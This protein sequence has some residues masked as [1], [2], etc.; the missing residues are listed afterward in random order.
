MATPKSSFIIK[1]YEGFG[2]KF[3]DSQYLGAS[4]ESDKPHIFEGK[5]M[6]LYSAK[7]R[8]FTSPKQLV[9]MTGA[10][11][12]GTMEIT[13][14]VYRWFLQGAETRS[15]IVMAASDPITSSDVMGLGGTW[16]PLVLDVNWY[17]H[18][19]VLM[20]EDNN[21]PL[22]V[23]DAT[24]EGEF[25]RYMVRIQGDDPSIFFPTYLTEVGRR[26]DKAWT[27]VQS[28]YNEVFGTQQMPSIM[29]LEHQIG[30]FAQSIHV[31]DRALRQQG[32]LGVTFNMTDSNGN[33]QSVTNFVPAF[34][35]RMQEEFYTSMEVQFMYGKKETK[36]GQSGSYW[37]KTGAGI[38][39]Q[40]KDGWTQYYSGS[41]NANL[42]Q[43]YV[44]DILFARANESDRKITLMTG[45]VGSIEF[46][47]ALA[48][49]ASGF[50]TVDSNFIE[51]VSSNTETPHLA[52]G[53]QFTR[54]RGLEGVVI[55]VVKNP[56][57]DMDTYCKQQ[58]PYYPGRPLDSGRLTVLDFGSSGKDNNIMMLKEK[59]T[60]KYGYVPG[61]VGPNGPITSGVFG[62]LKNGYDVAIQ[63]TGG[64]WIKDVTRCGEL[65]LGI[66]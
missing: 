16:F 20:G 58:H 45:T 15:S 54:Y 7:N 49:L 25:T 34:E 8:F 44:M 12:Y 46:H 39:E 24:P 60:F 51:K 41:L 47:K 23:M 57:Y 65:I 62:S 63:G 27:S 19:D 26:F 9:N 31:T 61:M 6:K 4:Y 36:P 13:N 28:E 30:A 3:L 5:L 43:D 2:G 48:N 38:R 18:P 11:N 40:L 55:D 33:E 29:E 66:D 53:A 32:R 52:Y 56:M 21:Y 59:D 37:Q 17:Q 22:Q 14:E 50:L 64:I 10:R 42:L 1:Q 35:A